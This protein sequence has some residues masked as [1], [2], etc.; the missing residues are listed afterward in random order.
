MVSETGH[1]HWGQKTNLLK[2]AMTLFTHKKG[3]GSGPD[4]QINNV[5]I[6]Y[7]KTI[8]NYGFHID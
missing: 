6:P 5:T 1:I 8:K 7:E 3:Q 4:I 2:S